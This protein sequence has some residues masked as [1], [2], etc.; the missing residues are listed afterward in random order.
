VSE[1]EES[2]STRSNPPAA[3]FDREIEERK[4]AL[5]EQRLK[6]ARVDTWTRFAG[7]VIVGALI[8]GGVQIYSKKADTRAKEQDRTAEAAANARAQTATQAQV[9]IQL[10][11]AREKTLT[12]LRAEMFSTLLQHYFKQ[13]DAR[14]R[15]AILELMALNF[16]DAIQIRP[17]L[18]LLDADLRDLGS[19]PTAEKM[20]AELNRAA[21]AMARDQVEQIRQSDGGGVCSL[22]LLL[23]HPINVPCVPYLSVKL[24][25]VVSSS[26][27]QVQTNSSE[28]RFLD[29]GQLAA[30]F[31]VSYFDT[32]MI[33]YTAVR[34]TSLD[35]L[36]FGIVLDGVAPDGKAA[37]VSVAVLPS[38][39]AFDA[40]RRYAFDELLNQY[41]RPL[42]TANP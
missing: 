34:P 31:E 22:K 25:H 27:I 28:G 2:P 37:D 19:N 41:L 29:S 30:P 5:D 18:E 21:R 38:T 16:R 4:L 14:Q 7:T 10:T 23:D 3:P 20:R 11:N 39:A 15:I 1:D 36:R 35:L 32:P 6:Q 8:A 33:D 12:D 40:Q 26:R 24:V 17:M 42:P 13:A 9:A